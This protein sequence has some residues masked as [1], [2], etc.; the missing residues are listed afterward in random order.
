MVIQIKLESDCLSNR[1]NT[2]R[3]KTKVWA[4]KVYD[5]NRA[6]QHTDNTTIA[7]SKD[8]FTPKLSWDNIHSEALA[9]KYK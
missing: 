3:N 7:L 8:T 1:E 6:A 5:V 9:M 4:K 2:R